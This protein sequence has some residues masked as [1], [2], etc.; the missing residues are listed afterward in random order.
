MLIALLDEPV[1][2]VFETTNAALREIEPP[3]AEN[4]IRALFD[5]QAVPYKIEWSAPNRR[6]NSLFG[7]LRSVEF[8]SYRF[9]PSGPP[10][11]QALRELLEA[12]PDCDPPESKGLL[13][14]LLR[15]LHAA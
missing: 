7:L 11:P 15:R 4:E 2:F 12:Y 14:E 3:D 13:D 10:D 9:V 5:D 1:L 6:R 8:G